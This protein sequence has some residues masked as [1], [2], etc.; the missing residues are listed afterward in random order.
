MVCNLLEN[1]INRCFDFI[2]LNGDYITECFWGN[3]IFSLLYF[4][5]K[6]TEFEGFP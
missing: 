5:L 4:S 6:T 2:T 1:E 3:D